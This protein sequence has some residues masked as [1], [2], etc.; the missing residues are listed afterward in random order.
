MAR[1]LWLIAYDIT[2]PRRLRRVA[3]VL[4]AHGIRAQKSV[5]ETHLSPPELARLRA[6]LM[7]EAG[8]GDHLRYYPLCA[9]CTPNVQWQGRGKEA[10]WPGY[11]V[12]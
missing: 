6:A 11:Y 2:S 5:F 10:D 3:R 7:A 8:P 1:Q 9:Q 12:V 4:E